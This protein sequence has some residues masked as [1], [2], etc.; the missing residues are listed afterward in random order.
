MWPYENIHERNY[1]N[2]FK[3][4]KSKDEFVQ[5]LINQK[6][7]S[8]QEQIHSYKN[9]KYIIAPGAATMKKKFLELVFPEMKFTAIEI[10]TSKKT[11]TYYL[12][13]TGKIKIIVCPFFDSKNGVGY[14]GL[15]RVFELLK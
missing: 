6:V 11:M 7:Q 4:L 8:I 13:E 12:G 10:K 15:E 14:E 2:G 1:L 9:L 3:N 5:K